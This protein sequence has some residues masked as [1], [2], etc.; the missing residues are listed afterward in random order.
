MTDVRMHLLGL[1]VVAMTMF[2]I[3]IASESV[4]KSIEHITL[5]FI[6]KYTR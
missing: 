3:A 4:T 1:F 6:I 2:Q 5:V